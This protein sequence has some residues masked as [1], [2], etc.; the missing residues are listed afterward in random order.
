ML[1]NKL[2]K[3][4]NSIEEFFCKPFSNLLVEPMSKEH[5]E[6][7]VQTYM[8]EQ[9]GDMTPIDD[10]D[11]VPFVIKLIRSQLKHRFT[12]KMSEPLQVFLSSV[13][14]SAGNTTMYLTYL[15]FWAKKLDKKEIGVGE[16]AT[17][18]PNGF[19]TDDSLRGIWESQKVKRSEINPL[20][21]DNL[22][23]YPKAALSINFK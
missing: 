9:S 3:D 15:Q 10:S 19:P 8:V 16:F 11:E 22:L 21:S 2:T 17:I 14:R 6:L 5:S 4:P 20:G 23:D 18:F 13:T 7:F 12:F 1:E